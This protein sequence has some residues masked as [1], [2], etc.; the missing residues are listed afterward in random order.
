MI[1]KYTSLLRATANC[2]EAFPKSPVIAYRR[3]ASLCDLLLHSTP[4]H[5]NSSSQKPTGSKKCNHPHC[6]AIFFVLLTKLE[7][8]PTPYLATKINFIY[9]QL[10]ECKKPT[11]H[12][13]VFLF[14]FLF[15]TVFFPH[16]FFS[17]QPLRKVC[18]ANRNI[19]QLF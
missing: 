5:E 15:L 16:I 10:I 12:C 18:I 6:Q 13:H 8:S 9:L 2:K 17:T 1:N 3:N 14:K 19:V 11:N 4:S 7:K